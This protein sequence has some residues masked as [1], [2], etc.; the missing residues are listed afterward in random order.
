M[1][2]ETLGSILLFIAAMIWGSSFI[3]MKSTVDFL[4]TNVLLFIR[5]FL[6]TIIL[7]IVFFHKIKQIR[8]KEI[9][10]GFICGIVLYSA[11]IVQTLGL[12]MTTPSKNAFLT[13]V[14]CA[15]VP[16]LVW[17]VLSKKPDNYNFIAA[18]LSVIGIGLVSLEGDLTIGLGDL[19]TLCGGVLWAI[20]IL[21]NKNFA[22]KMDPVCF[23][24]LQFMTTAMVSLIG[25]IL[26]EDISIITKIQSDIFFQLGYLSIFA[27]AITMLFQTI[28]QVYTSECRAS[29]I[30]SLES[31]F[32]VLFSVFLYGEV[33]S[34]RMIIGF[35][36]IF[37][38]IIISE[39][40]LEFL[41]RGH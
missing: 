16:F 2:K 34:I 35:I 40:K 9:K 4:S 41:K 11:Y 15:I 30:L 1:K 22:S 32:G 5:F 14:Y 37:I 27:T 31:V 12:T 25:A 28:G 29:L 18:F 7:S 21:V 39:T 17:I 8:L 10:M 33:L 3:V 19:L 23:T 20:H 38:A 36:F 13:A 26:F 24:I 6:G